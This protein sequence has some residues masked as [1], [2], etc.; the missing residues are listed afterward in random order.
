MRGAL[1]KIVRAMAL[2]TAFAVVSCTLVACGGE[3]AV[4]LAPAPTPTKTPL[5]EE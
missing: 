4:T 1:P 2:A 3:A 5:P